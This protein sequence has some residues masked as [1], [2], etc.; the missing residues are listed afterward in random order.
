MTDEDRKKRNNFNNLLLTGQALNYANN[1]IKDASLH[2]GH[3]SVEYKHL[4]EEIEKAQFIVEL[5]LR[6]VNKEIH[7]LTP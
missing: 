7:K 4:S 3:T 6:S 1:L 2:I 5:L